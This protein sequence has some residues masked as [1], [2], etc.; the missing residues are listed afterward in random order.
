MFVDADLVWA[1]FT[2]CRQTEVLMFMNKAPIHCYRKIQATVEASNFEHSS[3][4]QRQVW[5]WLRPYFTRYERLEYQYMDLL[6]CS[7]ITRPS[8]RIPSHRSMYS[9]RNIIPVPTIYA[10]RKWLLRP[11]GLLRREPKII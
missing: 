10:G 9:I 3:F 7:M 5:R 8:K 4:P 6:T 11:S 1:K 2:R